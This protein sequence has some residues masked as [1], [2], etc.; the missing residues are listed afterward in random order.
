MLRARSRPLWYWIGPISVVGFIIFIVYDSVVSEPK[1]K[2]AQEQLELEIKSIQPL[3]GATRYYYQ[4]THKTSHALVISSYRIDLSYSQIRAYYDAALARHG[5]IF[6]EENAIRDWGRD[7][8]GK[9]ARYCKGEY[10]ASLEYADKQAERIYV[11]AISWGMDS[12]VDRYSGK[13][14][15]VGCRW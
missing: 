10:R 1:A 8:G 5:W 14:L 15:K 9:A 2:L 6:Y 13:F 11:L 7:F 3:R 4:A 12:T